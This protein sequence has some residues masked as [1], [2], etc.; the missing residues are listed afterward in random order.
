MENSLS[1]IKRRIV[2]LD[3]AGNPSLAK[4]DPAFPAF[5]MAG[6]VF[7]PTDYVEV[8]ANFNYFKL[9]YFNHE[10]V[11]IHSREIASREGDFRFLNNK[12]QRENFLSD[13]SQ[14]IIYA[15]MQIAAAVILPN[16]LKDQYSQP[17]SPYHLA[18]N[19]IFE[20]VFNYACK[21][22]INHI[23]FIAEARGKK[24]DAEL[25]ETFEWLRQKDQDNIVRPFPRFINENML[26]KVKMQLEF[27]KKQSNIVGH[28]IAD[29]IASPIAWTILRDSK[30]LSLR[31]FED[32]FLYG[33]QNGLK[34]FPSK[35]KP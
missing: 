2:F 35:Q 1:T 22:Q 14:Q 23:H 24:E 16:E 13:I 7:S 25:Y 15:Q 10:G 31:Y 34:V 33:I 17:F 3:E 20:K 9:G 8:V 5:A 27:R 11:V 6:V 29:L 19:F 30:H 32:K 12:Q 18:F 26:D 4:V 28:Q 21:N